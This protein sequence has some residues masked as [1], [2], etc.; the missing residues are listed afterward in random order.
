MP[1]PLSQDYN[2][3]VQDSQATFGDAELRSGEPTLNRLGMPVPRSGNFADVYQFVCPGTG[4]TWAVKCFTRNVPGL[5]QR[6]REISSVLD[7]L[8]LPFTVDFQFLQRG[9][10][11]RGDW[12]PILKM[13]WIDGLLLNEFVR[14]NADK[15]ILLDKLAEI[16][17]RMGFRLREAGI[18]HCDLQHGNVLLVA[19]SDASHMA[20]KLVDYDGMYLPSLSTVKSGEVGHPNYQHPFRLRDGIYDASIDRVPLLTATVA[21]RALREKGRTLWERY[22]NGDNLLFKETDLKCPA[23]SPLFAELATLADEESR[24]LV[25]TLRIAVE[26]G[27]GDVPSLDAVMPPAKSVRSRAPAAPAMATA[28]MWPTAPALVT[29]ATV[30]TATALPDASPFDFSSSPSTPVIRTRIP[31]KRRTAVRLGGLLAVLLAIA[32]A[33]AFGNGFQASFGDRP[34]ATHQRGTRNLRDR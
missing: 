17:R 29:A 14:D 13:R 15:P 6:Y 1:W 10:R 24:R 7:E 16:W 11:I 31:A 12:F 30:P 27:W 21:L 28:P 25:Q 32:V 2:E 33:A 9:V 4:N 20:L 26:R 23:R 3:A 34:T 8:K 19:G 18:A 22:D 5:R